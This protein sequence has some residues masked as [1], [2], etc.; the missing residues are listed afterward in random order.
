MLITVFKSKLGIG[1]TVFKGKLHRGIFPTTNGSNESSRVRFDNL[2]TLILI[3]REIHD[4]IGI[5]R[6]QVIMENHLIYL[7]CI[8]IKSL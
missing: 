2:N 3:N 8:Y 7:S 6:Q 4:V 5:I 1:L